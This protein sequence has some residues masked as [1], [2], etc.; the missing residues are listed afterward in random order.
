MTHSTDT[1]D[2]AS[3]DPD[4]PNPYPF[5]LSSGQ[6]F[7]LVV[8]VGLLGPGFLVNWLEQANLPQLGNVVWV[9][10]Y[11]TMV[12]VVWFVW[13]R[14]LDLI[15]PTGQDL[16]AIYERTDDDNQPG[17]IPTKSDTARE[18]P[19]DT[20]QSGDNRRNESEETRENAETDQKEL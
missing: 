5:G 13:I 15:G 12:F 7:V 18:S 20:T 3:G 8:L 17:S 9:M 10:G 11:G 14:P 6:F 2:G 16:P 4:Q 19:S 1:D